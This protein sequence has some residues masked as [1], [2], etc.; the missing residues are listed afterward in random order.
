VVSVDSALDTEQRLLALIVE[1][2]LAIDMHLEKI[3]KLTTE[4]LLSYRQTHSL[5][6][7]HQ[8]HEI[9]YDENYELRTH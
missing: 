4:H 5:Q 2:W 9:L 3:M 8:L 7:L 6:T 1:A